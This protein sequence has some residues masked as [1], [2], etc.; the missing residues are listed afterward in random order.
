MASAGPLSATQ[1]GPPPEEFCPLCFR[2]GATEQVYRSHRLRNADGMAN[3]PLL[4][5]TTCGVCCA[6]GFLAHDQL[7]CPEVLRD[8]RPEKAFK[9]AIFKNRGLAESGDDA[10]RTTADRRPPREGIKRTRHPTAKREGSQQ[11][12]LRRRKPTPRPS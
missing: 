6:R 1:E 2:R 8:E 4:R 9:N 5:N 11:K 12:E 7:F 10:L 3:C